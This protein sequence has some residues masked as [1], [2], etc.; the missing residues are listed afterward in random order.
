MPNLYNYG[1]K[2]WEW[3]DDAQAQELV[4]RGD[5]QFGE[6]EYVPVI[7]SMGEP[8]EIPAREAT[9]AFKRGYTYR[10]PAITQQIVKAEQERQREEFLS[11]PIGTAGAFATGLASGFTGSGSDWAIRTL[12]SEQDVENLRQMQELSPFATGVGEIIGAATGVGKVANLVRAPAM[13]AGRKLA[14]VAAGTAAMSKNAARIVAGVET[15][16]IAATDAALF[17]AGRVSRDLAFRD[18]DLSAEQA[19]ANIGLG[20]ILG[21]GLGFGLG[22]L[23][24]GA[25]QIVDTIKDAGQKI[26]DK[27]LSEEAATQLTGALSFGRGMTKQEERILQRNF[28]NPALRDE[29]VQALTEPE[30]LVQRATKSLE[31]FQ[32]EADNLKAIMGDVREARVTKGPEATQAIGTPELD[33]LIAIQKR[34]EAR[35][36]IYE[37]QSAKYST[38]TR[39]VVEEALSVINDVAE[40]ATSVADIHKAASEGL[41]Y[42]NSY[43]KNK[44]KFNMPTSPDK[45]ELQ[46]LASNL[47]SHLRNPKLYGSLGDDYSN[48]QD[49]YANFYRKYNRVFG[50]GKNQGLLAKDAV[51]ASGNVIRIVNE[52]AVASMLRSPIASPKS[53]QTWTALTELY[54]ASARISNTINHNLKYAGPS[55]AAATAQRLQRAGA[56][57]QG[58]RIQLRKFRVARETAILLNK[59]EPKTGRV[60]QASIVSGLGGGMAAGPVGAAVGAGLGMIYSNPAM[61]LK[62]MSRVKTAQDTTTGSLRRSISAFLSPVTRRLSQVKAPA[63]HA[64]NIAMAKLARAIAVPEENKREN[65]MNRVSRNLG[66]MANDPFLVERQVKRSLV[67]MNDANFGPLY[68][69][70]VNTAQRGID[71][72]ASKVPAP[73]FDVLQLEDVRLSAS[74]QAKFEA[75]VQAVMEPTILLEELASATITPE[76]VEA[77]R[78]VYPAFYDQVRASITEYMAS[79]PQRL[80]YYR[81]QQ[82]GI[83]FDIKATKGMQNVTALQQSF[84]GGDNQKQRSQSSSRTKS[85][86]GELTNAQTVEAREIRG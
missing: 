20:A 64:R 48:I 30:K 67:G 62:V 86:A 25:G 83:L 50:S 10:S 79:K 55:A 29:T 14:G 74:Q 39:T 72:L 18:P 26:R 47:R 8:A 82:L 28:A 6:D 80:D 81:K 59:M 35:F 78:A 27:G 61:L 46:A 58:L 22:Y 15:G 36:P 37:K 60:V 44:N 34:A 42:L 77:V 45:G 52:D 19:V 33:D 70:F 75:Y 40:K 65:K 43:M 7:N 71:F 56:A 76:T 32:N 5:Y 73:E 17:E 53:R 3:I 2:K 21:G 41:D 66:Q 11:G 68:S 1:T 23:G 12:A 24:H 69:S 16:G 54:D 63:I 51:N 85:I 38:A 84:A 31:N 57:A 13:I 9:A 4:A 49:A